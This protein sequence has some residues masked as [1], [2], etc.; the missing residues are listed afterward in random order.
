M[1]LS[2]L[3]SH[4]AGS[5][6]AALPDLARSFDTDAAVMRAMLETLVRKGWVRRIGPGPGCPGG[7]RKCG[8]GSAE[9]YEWTGPA[10]GTT[11]SAQGFCREAE[12]GLRPVSNARQ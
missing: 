7:C 3:R 4:L 12:E 1:I 10:T 11:R 8:S 2:N 9:I 5:G 6:R